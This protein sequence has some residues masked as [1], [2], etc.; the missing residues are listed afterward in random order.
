MKGMELFK[1]LI[2]L[3]ISSMVI[4]KDDDNKKKDPGTKEK[5]K[6][7]KIDKKHYEDM[8]ADL[9]KEIKELEEKESSLNK[10]MKDEKAKEGGGDKKKIA[11]FE[12]ELKNA[13]TV[14]EEKEI[15]INGSVIPRLKFIKQH[16]DYMREMKAVEDLLAELSE[17]DDQKAKLEKIVGDGNTEMDTIYHPIKFLM[18]N[19]TKIMKNVTNQKKKLE[20]F[21]EDDEE[22]KDKTNKAIKGLEIK[23]S[24]ISKEIDAKLKN[25]TTIYNDYK[26]RPRLQAKREKFVIDE[27]ELKAKYMISLRRPKTKLQK[28]YRNSN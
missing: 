24:P 12:N 27:K 20:S 14:K 19:E 18:I 5:E 1:I 8:R 2:I 25:M 16:D 3:S 13:T 17:D 28:R 6:D 7:K 26:T 4:T 23:L 10:K 11:E 9:K 21:D 15:Y 22:N